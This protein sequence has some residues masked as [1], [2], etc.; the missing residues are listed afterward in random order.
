VPGYESPALSLNVPLVTATGWRGR[1]VDETGLIWM[2]A[3]YYDPVAGRFHSADPLGHSASQDLY[4]AFNGDPVNFYDPD[5]RF[6]KQAADFAYNG[7][8]AGYGLREL[9]GYLDNYNNSSSGGGWA[10]GFSGALVNELAGANAPSTYVNALAGFGN[11][12]ST[13]YNDG[14]F[15][16]AASYAVSGWNVG[17]VYS[18]F[19]NLDLVTGEEVGNWYQR[20]S[21]ISGGVAS[22][23]G[24]AAGGLGIYN[25]V[26][27]PATVSTAPPVL[28]QPGQIIYGALDDLGRPT[29]AS[30]TLTQDMLG[31]G[32]RANPGITPPGFQGGFG[33]THARGHLIG[34]QLGGSGDVPQN[35]VTILQ[36]PAN[37][38]VMRG[39]ENAAAAAVRAGQTVSYSSVPIYQGVNAVPRGITIISSGSGGHFQAV[40]VLNPIP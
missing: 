3:R 15:L 30:A 28:P 27:A 21:A 14:G 37:T 33:T 25:A 20:G 8:L 31:T 6:G 36:N 40:T 26:T 7:G 24:I 22:T 11:N 12:V 16:P 34:R 35:L 23:A 19:A 38:P 32:T 29:G 10:S 13:I 1:R 39:F 18:G 4:S 5:G 9:G 17:K 2:G